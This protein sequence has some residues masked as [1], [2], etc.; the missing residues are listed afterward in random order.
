MAGKL[1]IV[2]T[3]LGNLNDFSP[4]GREVLSAVDFIAAEDTRVTAK[5]LSAFNIQKPLVSY[6]EHNK[7]ARQDGIVDRIAAGE[8]CAIVTDAG[9]PAISDP[10]RDLVK[11]CRKCGIT[12]ETVPGA[13]AL[14]T[15]L[16]AS[17]M[18]CT[19]FCFEGFMP[20]E[21]KERLYRLSALKNEERTMVFYEAPHKLLDTLTDMLN[22]LGEREICLA[23]ELT[24][25][26]EEVINTTLSNAVNKY[27]GEAPR[28]EFVLILA[29]KNREAKEMSLADAV[30]LARDYVN[31]GSSPT[32]AA[33]AAA[34][35][36]G[37]RKGDIYKA[38]MDSPQ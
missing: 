28:G 10:G 4:R 23:R 26:H 31:N 12:A 34:L 16:A 2:G 37:I 9:M 14:T 13:T 33:K 21:R 20:T 18:D 5:L 32:S 24:K 15:A 36:S 6:H 35:E 25:L 8:N 27:S 11:A 1:Y 3:P 19:R 17:G 30:A 22:I 38:L 29:G 7:A